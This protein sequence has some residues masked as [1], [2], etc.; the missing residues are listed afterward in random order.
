VVL[1]LRV[2]PGFPCEMFM[3]LKAVWG[4]YPQAAE[5]A[6]EEGKNKI[7]IMLAVVRNNANIKSGVDKRC[8]LKTIHWVFENVK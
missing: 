1:K 2:K 8:I 7:A 3:P 6:L 5:A 4:R